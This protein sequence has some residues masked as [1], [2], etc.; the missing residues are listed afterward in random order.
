MNCYAGYTRPLPGG[1]YW[2]ML[3][4]ARDAK[5]CPVLGDGGAPV[6]YPTECEAW[7]AVA[8]HLAGYL[9]GNMRRDGATLGE[10][11]ADIDRVFANF[12]KQRGRDRRIPVEVR[13]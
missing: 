9:N 10:M 3:R 1:G 6:I 7:K 8:Q 2:A 5:P 4:L 12:A 13:R 11:D